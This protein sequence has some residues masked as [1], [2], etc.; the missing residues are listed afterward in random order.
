MDLILELCDIQGITFS[1]FKAI[2]LAAKKPL[3]IHNFLALN[4]AP[5][6]T[7]EKAFFQENEK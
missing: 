2:K 6:L 5:F 4:N 1:V 3:E 7:G